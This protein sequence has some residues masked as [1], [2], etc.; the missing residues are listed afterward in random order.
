MQRFSANVSGDSVA[1]SPRVTAWSPVALVALSAALMLGAQPAFAQALDTLMEEIR[2]VARKKSEAEAAQEVP[3]AVSALSGEQLEATFTRDLQSLS[4]AIPN[5]SLE[6]IG[7]ISGTANFSIRGLGINSSIPSIDPTVG[8]FVDGMYLGVNTGVVFD[9]FDLEGIEVLRGPQGLL[10]GRNVTG[11]AVLVKTRKPSDEFGVHLKTGLEEGLEKTFAGSVTGPL[12]PGKVAGRMTAYYKDDDGWHENLFNGNDDFG[13]EETYLVR[14]SVTFMPNDVLDLTLRYEHGSTEGDGPAAQNRF[15]FDRDSYDF[16]IDEEGFIDADWD[17]VIAEVNLDVAFGD[18][19]ITNIFGWRDYESESLTDVD[20]TPF[21]IPFPINAQFHAPA[22]LFQDQISNEIRYSGRFL[23]RADLTVGFYY[24]EQD[25]EY[26]ETRDIRVD[27][28]PPVAPI[29]IQNF[30]RFISTAGGV[31]DQTTIGV[32]AQT[33]YD[34]T[35]E[36]TLNLGIR[37]TYEE[38]EVDLARL[39]PVTAGSR[40]NFEAETCNFDFHDK[41]D[42]NNWTPKVGLQWRP[43]DDMQYYAFWTQGVRSGGYNFRHTAL[44]LPHE[45]FEEEKQDSYELGAKLDWMGGRLRTNLA[46][47]YNEVDDMQ[48]EIN[49]SDPVV[50]V[51]QIIRN[52]ADAEIRGV[53]FELQALLSEYLYL[54][55]SVGYVDGD[56]TTVRFDL[57]GD[58]VLSSADEQLDIPRLAPVTYN[59]T[60]VH[61]FHLGNLG[62]L[63]SRVSFSHRDDAAYTDN[64]LGTLNEADMLDLSATLATWSDRLEISVYG[65]NLLDEVTE[66]NDTQLAALFGGTPG[67]TFSPLNNKGSRWGVELNYRY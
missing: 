50:G 47:F 18:G 58:G 23:D 43:N 66:G 48:R 62:T 57:N 38:K 28:F 33:D 27:V 17:Q 55:G 15:L 40:C 46:L 45:G 29:P 22:K 35:P 12:V 51:V 24:F 9:V 4:F 64:N 65:K 1:P 20:A 7:T 54:Q 42:W 67:F 34:I 41:N 8:V 25:M 16:S 39:V 37:Y 13:K 63:T 5:V 11:G 32:F 26:F 19:T 59:I 3:V 53:E 10:F 52:T 21:A 60:A 2:V 61:D 6:D 31:Q 14:P 56:Y 36:W 30:R 44:L 49:L